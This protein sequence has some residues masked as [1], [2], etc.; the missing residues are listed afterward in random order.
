MAAVGARHESCRGQGTDSF[1][2]NLPF[3]QIFWNNFLKEFGD[4]ATNFT[5]NSTSILRPIRPQ[6]YIQFDLNFTSNSTSIL[7]PIRPQFYVKFGLNF[8]SNSTSILRP[9][10]SQ[11]D[12]FFLPT[13]RSWGDMKLRLATVFEAGPGARALH[14]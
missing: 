3:G 14:L 9:D 10:R 5:S 13:V 8:T 4:F 12:T 1:S 2:K 11:W 6:F 7:L